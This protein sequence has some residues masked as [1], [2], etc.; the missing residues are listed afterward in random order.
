MIDENY[1]LIKNVT[2]V[3]CPRCKEFIWSLYRHDFHGCSC[4]ACTVDGGRD[5]LKFSF[6]PEV[7]MP[8]QETYDILFNLK[9]GHST[10]LPIITDGEGG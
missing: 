8:T 6:D 1:R 3:R 4:E 10:L 5:Y 9:T 2:G 7:G